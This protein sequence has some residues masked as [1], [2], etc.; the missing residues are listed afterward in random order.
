MTGRPQGAPGTLVL[1]S[2]PIGNLGDLSG[3]ARE[4]LASAGIVA[5]EDTRRTGRL[6]ELAGIP[7]PRLVALHA[8]NERE[9]SLSLVEELRSGVDV[10]VV[11][12]AGTP[13]LSDPGERLVAAAVDAG[14][15]VV[16][17]PGP[18]A[19]LAALV[20]SGMATGRWRFE[21]FLPRKGPAR[22]ERL[23]EI[24]SATHASV[25]YE[26][27]AR[28]EPTLRDL[29]EACGGARRVAIARELTKLHEQTWRGSLAEA[30]E[31]VRAEAPR[32]EHVLVVDAAAA[33]RRIAADEVAAGVARLVAQGMS[34]RDAVTAAVVL[35]GASRHDAYEAATRAARG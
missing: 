2:T 32:G 10:A 4:S 30:R 6:L 5:C 9:R 25:L 1:V 20:V 28:V 8:H 35:L 23:E 18:S 24:A 22:R 34:R 26:S 21:G 16:A 29:E 13:L 11:S 17:V 7:A 14:I 31:H 12:D 15:P 19:A 33:P 27:P 3:R